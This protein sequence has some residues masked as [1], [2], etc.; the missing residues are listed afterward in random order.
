MS[1]LSFSRGVSSMTEFV[2]MSASSSLPDA[3]RASY[4]ARDD[5]T[6]LRPQRSEIAKCR[7]GGIAY[8]ARR[9]HARQRRHAPTG[10]RFAADLAASIDEIAFDRNTGCQE[11]TAHGLAVEPCASAE[12]RIVP[13]D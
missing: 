5:R 13:A 9:Q 7:L 6:H 12:Q 8:E 1:S 2:V 3:R 10:G 11:Q 4:S